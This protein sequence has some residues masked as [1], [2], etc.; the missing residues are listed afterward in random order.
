M[1]GGNEDD[2]TGSEARKQPKVLFDA[3]EEKP[4]ADLPHVDGPTPEG[5]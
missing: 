1:A 5:D 4:K 2:A 3:E